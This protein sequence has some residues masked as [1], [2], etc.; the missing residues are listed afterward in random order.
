MAP[1]KATVK[2]RPASRRRQAAE[3][4]FKDD[5][6]ML[7]WK[8]AKLNHKEIDIPA[9][10]K[11]LNLSVGAARMR[12]FRLKAKLDAFE[13]KATGN[14]TTTATATAAPVDITMEGMEGTEETDEAKGGN[15]D[16]DAK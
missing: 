8:L 16:E 9:L 15:N 3:N 13:K 6:V 10:A 11:E 1:Q 5:E 12:W 2:S 14:E 7:L 4:N